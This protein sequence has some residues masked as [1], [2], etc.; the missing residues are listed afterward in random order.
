MPSIIKGSDNFNTAKARSI[1]SKVDDHTPVFVKTGANTL[2]IKAGTQVDN[3]GLYTFT[4]DTAI[5]M[6]T[7]NAGENYGVWVL[8]NGTAEALQAPSGAYDWG[9]HS[10]PDAVMI[11]GFH[12][13]LVA[14]GTTP[15]SGG[16][17]T[18][19]FTNTG[20]S[21]IWT[22][23]DVDKIAGINQYSLWD[24]NFR[25]KT[26]GLKGFA[27]DPEVRTWVA[28][29]F[30]GTEHIADGLSKAG[31]NI[32]SDTVPPKIPLAYGGNGSTSY[33]RLTWYEANEIVQSHGCRLLNHNEFS[34]AAFG[35]TE[36]QSLG[37]AGVTPALTIRQNGYTSRIGLEQ[38]TGH[39]YTWGM[40]IHGTDGTEWVTGPNRGDSYGIPFG[41]LFGGSR[42]ND[43]NSGSRCSTWGRESW[44]TT[45]RRCVRAA[46]DHLEVN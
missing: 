1:L 14:A 36:A 25:P 7:L 5:T 21:M 26:F 34:S 44:N 32:A 31:S 23:S 22:Q 40:I 10:N 12:Y 18:S 4:V 27:F 3:N 2:S 35:V 39:V 16:F 17:A 42:T 46:C 30:T 24:L 33:G 37:G 13:G 9:T 15:A 28:I 43:D 8:P 29:Y 11:G 38:A 41:S 45:W 20:G 19:G 6:P